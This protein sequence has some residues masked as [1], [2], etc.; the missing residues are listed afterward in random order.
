MEYFCRGRLNP[1]VTSR[2]PSGVKATVLT[3]PRCAFDG[4]QIAMKEAAK[5]MPFEPAEIGL[6]GPGPVVLQQ[7]VGAAQVVLIP[8]D[9]GQVHVGDVTGPSQG[10][11]HGRQLVAPLFGLRPGVVGL[12]LAA[13]GPLSA[14]VA[15]TACQVLATAPKTSSTR[16]APATSSG[17]R[18]LRAALRSR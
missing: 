4:Q 7:L 15:R 18:C 9:A 14:T 1:E 16:N 17:V 11:V 3:M 12:A 10:V 2:L 13:L 8:G 6:A 5:V